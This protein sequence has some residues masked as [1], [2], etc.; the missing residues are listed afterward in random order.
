MYEKQCDGCGAKYRVFER[1]VPFR[2]KDSIDCQECGS[3]LLSWNGG[4]V[5]RV[6]FICRPSTTGEALNRDD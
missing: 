6:E 5:Y 2:D 3:E 4:I 1:S